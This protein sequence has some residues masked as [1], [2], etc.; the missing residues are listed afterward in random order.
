MQQQ[1]SSGGGGGGVSYMGGEW[2]GRKGREGGKGEE[3]RQFVL[4]H[5][6]WMNRIK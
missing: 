5:S 4:L 2:G 6:E 3:G 1:Q